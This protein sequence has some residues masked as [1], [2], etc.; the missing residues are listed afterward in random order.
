MP[1]QNGGAD[2]SPTPKYIAAKATFNAYMQ[3]KIGQKAAQTGLA[4]V[5][6]K[7]SANLQQRKQASGAGARVQIG[8]GV[9]VS[10]G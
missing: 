10:G 7:R 4:G 5:K 1:D 9:F 3:A 8:Q 6:A 2:G